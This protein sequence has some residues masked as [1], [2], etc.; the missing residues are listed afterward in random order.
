[1]VFL[2]QLTKNETL[3]NTSGLPA[4]AHGGIPHD[5]IPTIT[6]SLASFLV[7]KAPPE[8]PY[9]MEVIYI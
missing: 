5:T 6:Y 3:V 8:S 1:M 9:K 7:T 4:P 2:I